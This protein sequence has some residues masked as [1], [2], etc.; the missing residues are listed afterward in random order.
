VVHLDNAGRH[1]LKMRDETAVEAR[2]RRVCG[3]RGADSTGHLVDLVQEP[4]QQVMTLLPGE[5]R[6]SARDEEKEIPVN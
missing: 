5:P 2:R 1:S 6:E 3:G 4:C